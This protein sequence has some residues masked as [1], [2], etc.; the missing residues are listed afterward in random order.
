VC[1]GEIAGP[2]RAVSEHD[3]LVAIDLDPEEMLA[4]EE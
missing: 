1:D 2:A 4:R 3:H